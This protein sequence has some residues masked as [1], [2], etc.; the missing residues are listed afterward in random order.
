MIVALVIVLPIIG[1][2]LALAAN[3]SKGKGFDMI[4]GFSM[5]SEQR[6]DKY[7][8]EAVAKFA[9]R[10]IYA[11]IVVI[12]LG[13]AVSIIKTLWP[14]IILLVITVAAAIWGTIYMQTNK[15]FRKKE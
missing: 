7:D 2:M 6:K 8:K 12:I 11:T 9:G 4:S 3:L 1:L 5:M 13:I 14:V 10:M 15:R